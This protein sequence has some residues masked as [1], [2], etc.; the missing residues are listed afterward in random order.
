[1]SN[2]KNKVCFTGHRPEKLNAS[3]HTIK[4]KL[5]QEIEKCIHEGY[6][7]FISGM[8]RGV[9]IWAAETVLQLKTKGHD[10]KLVC[11]LPYKEFEKNWSTEWK[12][13]YK[14][15]LLNSDLIKCT[16]QYYSYKCFKI[17]N[18][19][20]V[21]H[22]AKIIAVYDGKPGGTKNTISYAQNKN[23]QITLINLT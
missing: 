21:N 1:M 5:T 22:S 10:I 15:I 23:L 7:V 9:D 12:S 19:W 18:E 2:T 11:A 14:A 8:S 16:S 4:T 13:R 20:M 17:R 3:E 6:N